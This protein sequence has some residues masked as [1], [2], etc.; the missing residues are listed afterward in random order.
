MDMTLYAGGQHSVGPAW[1]LPSVKSQTH[2][3]RRGENSFTW[4]GCRFPP[5]SQDLGPRYD[6]AGRIEPSRLTNLYM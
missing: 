5:L 1:M 2:F 3:W 4:Q 6:A